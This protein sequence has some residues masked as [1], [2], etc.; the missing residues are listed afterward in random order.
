MA[1]RRVDALKRLSAERK[2]A[3]EAERRQAAKALRTRHRD[4]LTCSA[5]EVAERMLAA[6]AS[7]PAPLRVLTASA[8]RPHEYKPGRVISITRNRDSWHL[9]FEK[10]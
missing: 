6:H 2:A 3:R 10:P 7:D 5:A 8:A 4:C 9:R 1:T